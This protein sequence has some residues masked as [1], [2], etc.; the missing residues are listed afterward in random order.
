MKVDGRPF[1][2]IWPA[3]DGW[4]VEIIDQTR[5]PHAFATA[6]LESVGDAARAIRDMWVRGAPLLGATA[7]YAIALAMRG[8]PSDPSRLGG[9]V[10]ALQLMLL[11]TVVGLGADGEPSPELMRNIHECE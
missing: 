9:A 6:R 8:D 11:Q 10:D 5:L 2:T 1:R 3:D 7:A 4:A